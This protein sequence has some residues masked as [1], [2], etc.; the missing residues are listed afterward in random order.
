MLKGKIFTESLLWLILALCLY[1]NL[2]A[3]ADNSCPISIPTSP[4]NALIPDNWRDTC[5]SGTIAWND[6]ASADTIARNSSCTVAIT[7]E[8]KGA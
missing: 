6:P 3:H 8:L 7:D 4:G 2:P 5:V 1:L